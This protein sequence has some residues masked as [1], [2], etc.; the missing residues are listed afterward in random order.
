MAGRLA[1]SR[2]LKIADTKGAVEH[3]QHAHLHAAWLKGRGRL[4]KTEAAAK[5][6]ALE[7]QRLLIAR[8]LGLPGAD[9]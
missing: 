3:A 2:H 9:L 5:L 4:Y 6:Y 1:R 8:S 7:N